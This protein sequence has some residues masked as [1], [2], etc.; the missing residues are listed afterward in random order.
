MK[1]A[2]RHLLA[3]ADTNP[4][5]RDIHARLDA[6]YQLAAHSI[7]PEVHRLATTIETWWPAI[8]AVLVTGYSDARAEGYNRS[9]KHQGRNAFGFGGRVNQSRRIRWNCTR[10]HLRASA[11]NSA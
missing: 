9:A 8:E 1:E 5:R 7:A 4:D 3:L 10:Q 2:L 6:C 11:K